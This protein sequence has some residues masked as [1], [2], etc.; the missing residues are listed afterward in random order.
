M[1]AGSI[2]RPSGPR[3]SARQGHHAALLIL[4]GQWVREAKVNVN[5]KIDTDIW[6]VNAKSKHAALVATR[7]RH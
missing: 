1:D 3:W 2:P 5:D 6:D 7:I 4:F